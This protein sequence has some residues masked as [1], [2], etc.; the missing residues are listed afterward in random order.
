MRGLRLLVVG[1]LVSVASS[2]W[3]QDATV[4]GTVMDSTGGVLP[5]VAVT[6]VHQATGN[7]FQ[8]VTDGQGGF[9]LIVRTGE[10]RITAELQ[11][12]STVTRVLELLVGQRVTV[13]FQM[14]P[15]TIQE[16]VT[17]TG[18]APLIDPSKSTLATNISPQQ[19][20]DLPVNGRNW[21]DLIMLAAGSRQNSANENLG[22]QIGQYQ[23]NVD[24]LRVTQQMA[25]GSFGQQHYSED[26]IAEFEYVANRF[27][28]T[29]GGSAGVQVNAI[30]KS[31]TNAFAGTFS[32]F[33]R[34]DALIAKDFI[35][36]RVTPYSDNQFSVTYGGPIRRDRM[37]FFGNF[38]YEREPQTYTHTSPYP[39]FNLDLTGTRTE[40]KG[41]GRLDTQFSPRTRLTTRGTR[42]IN[43]TP[44]DPAYTGGA[45][46]HPS[47]TITTTK[48]G[49]D[50][51][52]NLTHVFSNEIVNEI[53]GGWSGF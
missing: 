46:R 22:L 43:A 38:E 47:S 53:V 41:G 50:L 16:S 37:H 21:Q 6:A 23:L 52:S 14:A 44:Y 28:A 17:V 15:S 34:N 12:F 5:G 20:Q 35:T 25:A 31:G 40:R 30:T 49:V 39:S 26:A 36:K 32:S 9:R 42:Y 33:F 13:N 24:G 27:D 1:L 18:E 4:I 48:W 8:S 2:A 11:G 29:Q 3:A 19:L 45:T 10:F 51:S 7:S